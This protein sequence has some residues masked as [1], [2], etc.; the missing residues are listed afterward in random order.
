MGGG[1]FGPVVARDP[2]LANKRPAHRGL[3]L[4]AARFCCIRSFL[5][6]LGLGKIFGRAAPLLE[7]VFVPLMTLVVVLMAFGPFLRWKDD[8]LLAEVPRGAGLRR[9]RGD[10][11]RQRG[12]WIT[13][14]RTA[15]GLALVAWVVLARPQLLARRPGERAGASAGLA[16]SRSITASWWGMWLAHFGI[17]IFII[18]VTMVGSL[19]ATWTS[20]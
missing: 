19:T 10:R 2:L 6:A 11:R 12:R 3:G 18:G 15:P 9:Q 17:G 13:T 4:G 20:R 7:T 1:S 16:P 5:D 14:W 8:D